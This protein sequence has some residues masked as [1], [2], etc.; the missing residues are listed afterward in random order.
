D[1][2]RSVHGDPVCEEIGQKV[3]LYCSAAVGLCLLIQGMTFSLLTKREGTNHRSRY[4][5]DSEKN[6]E[7]HLN[8]ELRMEMERMR[9]RSELYLTEANWK[10]VNERIEANVFKKKDENR[11][12][13]AGYYSILLARVHD[14]WI[15]GALSGSAAHIMIEL[16]EQGIDEEK[17][18]ID[19]FMEHLSTSE[20]NF[21]QEILLTIL[22]L[23]K[24]V[25]ALIRRT[26]KQNEEILDLVPVIKTRQ[27]IRM[28]SHTLHNTIA[29]LNAQ[30]L[31]HEE[32]M[33]V[34]GRY[35]KR[36][37]DDGDKIVM[38]PEPDIR[39]VLEYVHWIAALEPRKRQISNRS[40]IHK[41]RQH[42][43]ARILSASR[44]IHW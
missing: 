10:V 25:D 27:A 44:A 14:L 42:P 40:I 4:I 17:L 20:L 29:A 12:V 18:G 6:L 35:L 11:N 39:D 30:G 31:I 2:T 3:V 32:S 21:Y 26:M 28:A 37:R 1:F 41:G 38:A 19:D 43:S 22:T 16:L 9:K 8:N 36:L 13:C 23:L 5:K 34:W 7:H 33:A 24:I 15:R